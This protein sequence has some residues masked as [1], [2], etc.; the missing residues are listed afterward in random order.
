MLQMQIPTMAIA[1]VLSV[2]SFAAPL[3]QA[4][5]AAD[6]KWVL[7]LDL[8]AFR[9]TKLG[10]HVVQNVV[11]P[12]L[13]EA[14]ELKKLNLSINL[15]NISGITA[16]GSAFEKNGDGVLMVATTANV[17]KDLDTLVGM[18]ALSAEEKKGITMVQE[19]PY[20]LYHLHNEIFVAP[21]AGTVL[22]A[23]SRDQ[24]D[25]ARKVLSGG[26]KSLS[27]SATFDDYP[28]AANTFF[29][30]GMADGFN[31][32]ISIP[33]Q[34]QVLRETKGGRLVIGEKDQNVFLNL[35]FKGKNNEASTK[36][37]QVLQG[38]VALVSM[39]QQDKAITD[40]AASTKIGSEGQNVSVSL[41][42]PVAKA[43][44]KID[45]KHNRG[46]QAH[47][48]DEEEEDADDSQDKATGAK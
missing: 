9:Q 3:D 16:Y 35:V 4:K 13:E 11:E 5:V 47:D 15:G 12:K 43:I 30:L 14:H 22:L 8:E 48:D 24:I 34:A 36:I 44:Q 2:S 45:E 26:E 20:A 46:N 32:A 25:R 27:G 29:F 40:L 21:N 1:A 10:T 18:A 23:K 39:S 19:S 38:I 7:H 42:F 41:Q 6:A 33:P 17:K 37:Q 28:K 31:D